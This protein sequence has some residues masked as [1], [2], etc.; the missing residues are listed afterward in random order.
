MRA[1]LY[2]QAVPGERACLV[3]QGIARLTDNEYRKRR[4]R[5]PGVGAKAATALIK[6]ARVLPSQEVE[7]AFPELVAA[8]R[9]IERLRDDRLPDGFDRFDRVVVDEIQDLT[10]VEA[11]VVAELCQAIGRKRGRPPWLLMAGDAGQTV[12]PTDFDWGPLSDLL[13]NRVGTP[14]KF[15]LEEHLRCPSRIARVVDRVAESYAESDKSIRPTKQQ[16]QHGGQHVDAHLIYVQLHSQDEASA[17]LERLAD[18]DEVVVLSPRSDPL[19]WVPEHVQPS[20]LTPE[21]AKGLEYQSVCILDPGSVVASI[22]E[23]WDDDFPPSDLDQLEFRTSIDHLR[24]A[25]SRATETLVFIDMKPSHAQRQDSL[26]M[27]GDAAP[28]SAEDLI[29][30]FA[31]A[32]ASPEERVLARLNDARMLVDSALARAWQ[33]AHQAYQLLGDADLPNGVSDPA[34]RRETR[35]VLLSTAVRI[36]FNSDS[37]QTL[38]DRAEAF[39]TAKATARG[40]DAAATA[41]DEAV[42]ALW[43]WSLLRRQP[44]AL[45]NAALS[46]GRA[47]EYGDWLGPSLI[48]EAQSLRE[49]LDAAAK[50]REDA[51]GFDSPDVEGWLRLTSHEGDLAGKARGLRQAAFDTLLRA[52]VGD[53]SEQSRAVYLNSAASLMERISPDLMRLGRL[54][55]AQGRLEDAVDAY[56]TAGAPSEALRVWRNHGKW[57]R[58]VEF[59][60]GRVRA[61]LEWL[62]D[63]RRLIARRPPGQG[64]RLFDGERDRLER[65]IGTVVAKLAISRKGRR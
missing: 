28:Y 11:A 27:L 15:H 32:D 50:S 61:D 33:R 39:Q 26:W 30:H 12:R 3:D 64:E 36:I 35:T 65:L 13:S 58:A 17:L 60:E 63:L 53:G 40:P 45:L 14:A 41:E 48:L 24:V 18:A 1:V 38:D 57:E 4:G 31:H 5:F 34:L 22:P 6:A 7:A 55:E 59:A 54:R 42:Q 20:V 56:T 37:N 46:L 49:G 9:A 43:N 23:D 25:V 19:P 51:S 2:G 10:L 29:D 16:R 8:R 47:K 62:E 44:L 52:A 21:E